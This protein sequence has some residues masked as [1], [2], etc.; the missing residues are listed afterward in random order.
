MEII[1]LIFQIITCG[2]LPMLMAAAIYALLVEYFFR[3]IFKIVSKQKLYPLKAYLPIIIATYIFLLTFGTI[4]WLYSTWFGNVYVWIPIILGIL[5]GIFIHYATIKLYF[6][7][8][9]VKSLLMSIIMMVIISSS[10]CLVSWLLFR[11][12]YS[13]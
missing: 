9:F 6:K 12:H 4:L 8:N 2:L 13:V 11:H 10:F 3:L 5:C 7:L 1:K